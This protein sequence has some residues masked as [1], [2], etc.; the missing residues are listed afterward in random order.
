MAKIKFTYEKPRGDFI[1]YVNK[2]DVLVVLSRLPHEV[3]NMLKTV[4][5]KAQSRYSFGHKVNIPTNTTRREITL[6]AF[7]PRLSLSQLAISQKNSPRYFGATPG[8][9]WPRLAV[10]RYQLYGALLHGI[11]LLQ[12]INPDRKSSLLKTRRTKIEEFAAYWRGKL[13]SE[14]FDHPDPVHNPPDEKEILDSLT[15]IEGYK[16][17]T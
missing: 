3:W 6:F 12:I 15:E 13:W 2:E 11:G 17:V 16:K 1:H 14:K 9:Q 8:Y 7:P 10:R 5:F 4:H